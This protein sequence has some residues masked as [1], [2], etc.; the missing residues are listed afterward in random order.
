VDLTDAEQPGQ[1][2]FPTF[3]SVT[4][5]DLVSMIVLVIIIIGLLWKYSKWKKSAPPKFFS[6]AR[7]SL[8]SST[9]IRVFFSELVNRVLLQRGVINNDRIRRFTHLSM[10]WGFVGLSVTTTLDYIY[11]YPGNYIPLFGD[12]LSPIRWLGNV[13]GAVM[14]LGATIA[15]VRLIAL[16]K[17]RRGRTFGDVWFTV[18]LFLAGITGFIAEYW[19]DVAYAANP[20]VPP[21]AAYTL[22][23][24]ASPLI[25]VPYGIHLVSVGLLIVTAPA[26]AFIHAFQ[27]PTMRYWE[28]L[29]NVLSLKK[30]LTTKNEQ[31]RFKEAA[32][33]DQI[34][35]EYEQVSNE[36]REESD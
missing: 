6:T 5:I 1:G 12:A 36:K 30:G 17:F 27:V 2:T 20:N 24:S 4:L 7:L 33:L 8:G 14:V 29:G 19:G 3:V 9:L 10:F 32:M 26:S 31:R 23:F 18:L 34:Q 16:P 35:R 28:K 25:V 22:S 21:A 15:L 11:N 13:S